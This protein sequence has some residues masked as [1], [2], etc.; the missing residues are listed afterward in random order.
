MHSSKATKLL[1]AETKHV[2][3]HTFGA[4]GTVISAVGRRISLVYSFPKYG[5]VKVSGWIIDS[6]KKYVKS[7]SV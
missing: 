6:I 1:D 3:S 2:C 5:W 7:L 4:G